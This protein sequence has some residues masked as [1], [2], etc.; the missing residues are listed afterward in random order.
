[1]SSLFG[2]GA[3]I[4]PTMCIDPTSFRQPF[5]APGHIMS[6]LLVNIL[7][8]EDNLLVDYEA[9]DAQMTAQQRLSLMICLGLEG[10]ILL[11]IE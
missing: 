8:K 2:T 3:K 1:M 5:S 4:L 9:D 7:A 10:L 11:D 6:P